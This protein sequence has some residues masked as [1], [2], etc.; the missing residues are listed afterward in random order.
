[1]VA[2]EAIV[3]ALL[4]DVCFPGSNQLLI[5]LMNDRTFSWYHGKLNIVGEL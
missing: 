1:M 5:I 4:E 2:K 3:L